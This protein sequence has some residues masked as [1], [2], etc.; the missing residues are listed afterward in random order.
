MK[1][2]EIVTPKG[3]VLRVMQRKYENILQA[4][5]GDS[6]SYYSD[7]YLKSLGLTLREVPEPVE[8][9]C[10]GMSALIIEG[11]RTTERHRMPF[12]GRKV[13]VRVEVIE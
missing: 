6:S 9:E 3:E 1:R 2:V 13:R 4:I 11:Y 12:G 7:I 8:F 10:D 5:G